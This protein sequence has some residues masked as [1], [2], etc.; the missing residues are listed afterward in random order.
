MAYKVDVENP[1]V[2]G[3]KTQWKE[4]VLVEFSHVLVLVDRVT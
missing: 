3:S 1:K 4:K 2:S